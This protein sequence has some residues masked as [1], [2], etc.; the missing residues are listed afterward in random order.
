MN[1]EELRRYIGITGFSLGQ[2]EKDYLQHVALGALSRRMGGL[3]VFKGGTALQ[4][5][6]LLRRFSEDLD[7]TLVGEVSLDGMKDAVKHVLGS[8]NFPADADNIT[9]DEYSTVAGY[10]H[11]G[12]QVFG[13]VV[14]RF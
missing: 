10:P 13:G 3:L 11:D 14:K 12:T 4:K 6:G 9:D 5:T 7:F 2:V 8:Y 1:R